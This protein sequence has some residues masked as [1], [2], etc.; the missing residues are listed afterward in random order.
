MSPILVTG[1][2]GFIGSAVV[3]RLVADGRVVVNVDALTYAG[4][5][6][7]LAAARAAPNHHFEHIDIADAAAL[8]DMFRRHAPKTVIH[9]A[10]ESHVDRS[11][12]AP[13]SF[14][15]T[16]LVGTFNLL[17]LARRYG[18]ERFVHVSTD[19]VFGTLGDEGSFDTSSPY[20]PRS[21]YAASK[22]GADHLARA[23]YHTFDLPVLVTNCS[24]N[25]G[26]CQFPEKLIPLTILNALDGIELAVY[27]DGSNVRDWI[28][29]DDHVT[30]LLA[31]LERGQPGRTYLFGGGAERRNL[32]VVQS[33]C[34]TLDVL[35]PRDAGPHADLIRFVTDRPGHDYR[36]AIDASATHDELGWQPQRSFEQGLRDT[37][38]WYLQHR[39]DWVA[40]VRSGAYRGERLGLGL[41]SREA[42]T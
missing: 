29:V 36:Y 11:I 18:V 30:G 42:A 19:E 6:D 20:D 23:W 24:N 32:D 33:I 1:G 14:V 27:G 40:R 35:R 15:R 9:L 28:H 4:N 34:R 25:Y 16:N 26:P 12:D 2:A 13:D 17:Q 31:V 38:E 37:V 3:R 21:P 5:L 10:A 41:E 22:A 7:S 39:D 8:D